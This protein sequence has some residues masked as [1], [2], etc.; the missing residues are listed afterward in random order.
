MKRALLLLFFLL[1]I[2]QWSTSQ[3]AFLL[4]GQNGLECGSGFST[5]REGQGVKA[6][7]GYSYHGYLDANLFYEKFNGGEI[8]G[9]VL[10]PMVTFYL[11][12]QEDMESIPTFGL[13]L[14]F[15]H[16]VSKTSE[17]IIVPDTIAVRWRSYERISESTVNAVT[18]GVTVQR[19]TGSWKVFFFQPFLGAGFSLIPAGWDFTLRGGLSVGSQIVHGPLVIFTPGIELQS[20]V[21]TGVIT[22]GAVF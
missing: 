20:G 15:S 7:A 4:R 2:A 10:T 17:T 1:S 14:G 21:T 16:Y 13:S 5:N 6:F 12:K 22:M 19:R 9:G 3:S 8:Q 11:A 18:L